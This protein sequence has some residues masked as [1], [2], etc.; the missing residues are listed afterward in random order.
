MLCTKGVQ[1]SRFLR[2]LSTQ[3]K[4]Y[5][6]PVIFETTNQFSFKFYITLQYHETWF[7]CTVLAETLYIFNKKGAYQSTNL[8]KF[9]TRSWKSGICTLISF[10][11]LNHAQFQLKKYRRVISHNHEE[12]I[13]SLKKNWLV[14]SNMKW[15]IWWIFTQPLKSLK[16]YFYGLFLSEV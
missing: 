12:F 15:G 13:Q 8:V 16:F 10:F 3:V 4:I 11:C 5:Q 14:V 7:L 2:L 9:H 1:S 6:I